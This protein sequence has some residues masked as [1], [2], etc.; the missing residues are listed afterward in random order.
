M[1]LIIILIIVFN[2]IFDDPT[3]QFVVF[4][5]SLLSILLANYYRMKGQK[6]INESTAITNSIMLSGLGQFHIGSNILGIILTGGNLLITLV[7]AN[8]W[9]EGPDWL[10]GLGV[11]TAISFVHVLFMGPRKN[12][13][14]AKKL[15]QQLAVLKYRQL[16]PA[17]KKGAAFSLD[18]NILMH[19][20][21]TL[22][23]AFRD[24][25]L[26]LYISKQVMKELDGLKNNEDPAVRK[27]AQVGFDILELYQKENR[28]T[29]LEIP[30]QHY[31]R[32][33]KLTG[34]PDE[35]IIASCLQQIEQ[36]KPVVFLSNDKGARILARN[37]GVPLMEV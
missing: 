12:E 25:H 26:Q 5:Y 1:V 32:K 6:N 10:I 8:Q 19:E 13:Q 24:S 4:I 28:L 17:I 22:V 37:V 21:L 9:I 35:K 36:N 31:L 23:A 29:F 15:K 27:R 18:T 33:N 30:N 14:Q 20:P 2:S 3:A 11:L 7:G 16:E 34:G